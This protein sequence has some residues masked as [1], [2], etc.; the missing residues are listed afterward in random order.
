ME[1]A[2]TESYCIKGI[3]NIRKMI[4]FPFIHRSWILYRYRKLCMH[5]QQ[6]NKLSKETKGTNES[7][8][9]DMIKIYYMI[10]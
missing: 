1:I 6:T 4:M 2:E 10:E 3:A 9:G 5:R 7:R 8:V